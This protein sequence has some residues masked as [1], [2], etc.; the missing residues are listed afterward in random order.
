MLNAYNTNFAPCFWL[1]CIVLNFQARI[2]VNN[3]LMFG[4][5][6]AKA[7]TFFVLRKIT[8]LNFILT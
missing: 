3:C 7:D 4:V 2:I 5:G 6:F 1:M 8:F